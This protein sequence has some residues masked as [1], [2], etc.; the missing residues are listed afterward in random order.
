MHPEI[1]RQLAAQ[2]HRERMAMAARQR[3]GSS[4]PRWRVAWSVAAAPAG[5]GGGRSWVIV[6]SAYRGLP[7][8]R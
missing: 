4:R 5:R 7:G 8:W 1:A 6:V 3:I 2:R